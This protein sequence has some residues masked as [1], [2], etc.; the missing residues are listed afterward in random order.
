[1]EEKLIQK[2]LSYRWVIFGIL[3]FGYILVYFHR[4]S[5]SVVAADITKDFKTTGSVLGL[6][7]SIYFYCYAA[8]QF[9]AGLL[10]DS[11][12]PRKTVTYSL[13]LAAVGSVLFGMAPGIKTAFAAR[14]MVGLGAS[15]VFIPTMKILSQWFKHSEFALMAGLLNGL[16]GVG[17]LA[18]TWILGML[19]TWAGWRFSFGIIGGCT[20]LMIVLAWL[21]VRD[22]PADKGWPSIAQIEYGR[23]KSENQSNSIGLWSG[24]KRVISERYFWPVAIWFFFDCGIFFGFGGLWSGP[25]LAH[26]YGMSKGQVGVILS[27][28]AW[29]M[30]IGSPLLGLLSEKV[31]KSR[32]K[33]FMLCTSLLAVLFL[34][35][36]LFPANLPLW[37]LYV[38]FFMFS[39][40]SSSIVIMAFTTTKELFPIEI[41]GT[42]VGT[43]NF[44]PFFGGAVFQWLLGWVLDTVGKTASGGYPIKAYSAVLLILFISSL[45]SL[46][47]TFFMKETYRL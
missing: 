5:M 27:M 26:S 19:A 42:S 7:G 44:F 14:I 3:A 43:V 17:I 33:T 15:L 47:C 22:R 40:C 32:K 2:V 37:I 30:I 28:L 23:D 12:G 16:G 31:L 25:Y 41:A 13:L 35:L 10:S 11:V 24:A 39:V 29:G 6:L 36:Y 46:G 9:P 18:G 8:M 1:M 4:V 20:L 21:W 38:W 45:I 34:F